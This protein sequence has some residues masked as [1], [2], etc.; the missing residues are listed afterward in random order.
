MEAL[1][2]SGVIPEAPSTLFFEKGSLIGLGLAEQA[3]MVGQ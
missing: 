2:T 3:S 1:K